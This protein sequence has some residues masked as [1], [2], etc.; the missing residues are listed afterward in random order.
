MIDIVLKSAE[1]MVK[2]NKALACVMTPAAQ[3]NRAP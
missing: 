3:Q 1:L 2:M